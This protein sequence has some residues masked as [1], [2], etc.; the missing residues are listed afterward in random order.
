M[1]L[2]VCILKD[3]RLVEDIL[4]AFVEQ[5]V[6]G[7]TVL[8]GRGMGQIIANELPIFAG[9]RGLFPGAAVDSHV[10]ISA[11][12]RGKAFACLDLVER[13]AGPFDQPGSGIVFTI[14]LERTVGAAPEFT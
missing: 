5:G 3:Y 14:P 7:A 12:P 2:L 11:M 4:L 10:I 13:L 9:L 1:V 8:E 6:S